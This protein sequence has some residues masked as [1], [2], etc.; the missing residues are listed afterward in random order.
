MVRTTRKNE[1]IYHIMAI[2]QGYNSR[3]VTHQ[4]VLEELCKLHQYV[5][6]TKAA[7]LQDY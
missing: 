6:G 5:F 3:R 2:T 1:Q 4:C 7:F